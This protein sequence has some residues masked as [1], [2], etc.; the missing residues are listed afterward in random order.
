MREGLRGEQFRVSVEAE[1]VTLLVHL[2]GELDLS[3]EALATTGL[4]K[5]LPIVDAYSAKSPG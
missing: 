5:T 3:G 4:D 1:G 2:F